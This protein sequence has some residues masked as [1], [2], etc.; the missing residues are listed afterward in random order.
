MNPLYEKIKLEANETVLRVIR[1]HWFVLSIQ[2]FGLVVSALLPFLILIAWLLFGKDF[3]L[4]L[5][6]TIWS[7]YLIF[8]MTGWILIHVM[9]LAYTWT[10]WYLDLWIITDRRIIS[11]DQKRLFSRQVG[12][13][14]LE[15]LQDMNI[16]INGIIA[17]FLNYGNVEAQTASGSEEEFQ[18][19]NLPDPRGIKALILESSDY[20][21]HNVRK[22]DPNETSW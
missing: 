12:S 18:A 6:L 8:A 4:T 2:L 11:I 10:E 19:K 22:N 9:A 13:F 20:R 3:P 17:T 7:D 1:R 14:R 16:E 21:M 15:R 5:D